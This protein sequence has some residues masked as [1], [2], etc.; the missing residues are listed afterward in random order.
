[1]SVHTAAAKGGH[2]L[3]HA[4]LLA[5]PILK[6]FTSALEVQLHGRVFACHA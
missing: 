5:A 3:E 2:D 6:L 1:M 4:A